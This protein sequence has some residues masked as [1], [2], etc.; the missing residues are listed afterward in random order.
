[1][2][3]RRLLTVAPPYWATSANKFWT[4]DP[5]LVARNDIKFCTL[6]PSLVASNDNGPWVLESSEKREIAA[7]L[8]PVPATC[9]FLQTRWPAAAGAQSCRWAICEPPDR[10]PMDLHP[11][12]AVVRQHRSFGPACVARRRPIWESLVGPSLL[13]QGVGWGSILS[14]MLKIMLCCLINYQLGTQRRACIH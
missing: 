8:I 1:M 12:V 14:Y 3:K 4:L 2:W 11:R 10:H 7:P 9:S 5:P 13:Q 6:H